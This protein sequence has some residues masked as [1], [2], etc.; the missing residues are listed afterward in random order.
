M[1]AEAAAMPAKPKNAAMIATTR[2]VR[3]HPSMINLHRRKRGIPKPTPHQSEHVKEVFV[4]RPR[5]VPGRS[6]RNN[7]SGAADEPLV[8]RRPQAQRI[9]A[10][11]GGRIERAQ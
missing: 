5:L 9:D 7:G 10:R 8:H 3:A 2:N 4:P 1:P 11:N 6:L